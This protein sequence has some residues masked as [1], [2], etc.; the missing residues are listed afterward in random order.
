MVGE[1]A[2]VGSM[3][4]RLDAGL[5][6]LDVSGTLDVGLAAVNKHFNE[7]LFEPVKRSKSGGEWSAFAL[8]AYGVTS[9]PT[10]CAATA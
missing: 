10:R 3:K 1:K 4:W 5:S 2:E 9:P 7:R 8:R 6:T